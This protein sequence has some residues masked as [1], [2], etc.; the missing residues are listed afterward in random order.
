MIRTVSFV[1]RCTTRIKPRLLKSRDFGS[2]IHAPNHCF[3]T[4]DSQKLDEVLLVCSS[5]SISASLSLS[6]FCSSHR[7]QRTPI[8]L[9]CY[10]VDSGTSARECV[11]YIILDLRSVQEIKQV[12][13]AAFVRVNVPVLFYT[14]AQRFG[15]K[16]LKSLLLTKAA[17]IQSQML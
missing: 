7:L 1:I 13:S 2:L 3:E 9:Q 5:S 15:I 4:N 16:F 12:R 8:K 6:V 11:G 14:S 10:A 17:F